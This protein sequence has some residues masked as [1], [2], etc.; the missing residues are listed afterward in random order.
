MKNK[1]LLLTLVSILLC[2]C[3]SYT[4][5]RAETSDPV[6]VGEKLYE[7]NKKADAILEFSQIADMIRAGD[8]RPEYC[9]AMYTAGNACL[10]TNRFIEALDFFSLA[11]SLAEKTKQQQMVA[12]LFTNIGVIYAI[13]NDDAK[14]SHYF[15][16]AYDHLIKYSDK[17]VLP[18]VIANLVNSY[19][20][21]GKVDEARK[22]FRLESQ[23]PLPEKTLHQYHMYYNQGVIARASNNPGANLYYQQKA[24]EV[25]D[26]NKMPDLMRTDLYD[27]IGRSYLE[28]GDTAKALN[29]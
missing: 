3:L 7:Q 28:L 17:D 8:E 19:S 4:A 24:M 18:I 25:V 11:L 10:E 13:F 2:L 12:R 15:Q 14:A 27:E 6:T 21:A 26:A 29:A 9:K 1:A 22:Y 23:H 16:L 5:M 20:K